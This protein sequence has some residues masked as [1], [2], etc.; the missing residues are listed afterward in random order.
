MYT[1]CNL[2]IHQKCAK[3]TKAQYQN[4]GNNN[5]EPW[6]RRPCK[7]ITLRSLIDAYY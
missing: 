6:Y 3:I 5:E 7:A 4:I 2:W 1:G